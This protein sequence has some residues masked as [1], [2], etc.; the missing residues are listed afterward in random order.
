[1]QA[2]PAALV[3]H[4]EALLQQVPVGGFALVAYDVLEGVHLE[5]H[6]VVAAAYFGHQEAAGKVPAP[7]GGRAERAAPGEEQNVGPWLPRTSWR[8]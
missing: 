1:M 8:P 6:G 4:L 2:G 3:R 5:L 7:A